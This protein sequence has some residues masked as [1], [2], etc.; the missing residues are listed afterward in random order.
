MI[1]L[2]DSLERRDIRIRINHD[3]LE[4]DAP[5][6]RLTPQSI[7]EIRSQKPEIL[8]YLRRKELFFD[9]CVAASEGPLLTPQILSAYLCP[10]D[11]DDPKLMTIEGLTALART[12]QGSI[13]CARGSVPDDWTT[14]AQCQHCGPIWIWPGAPRKL[15]GCPWCHFSPLFR[16]APARHK[17]ETTDA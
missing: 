1:T 14:V 10:D 2:V 13:M 4:I 5:A 6:G 7:A 11:L 3:R 9:A 8:A 15:R 17:Q 12:I 16:P